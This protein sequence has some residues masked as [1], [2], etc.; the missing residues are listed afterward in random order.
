VRTQQ[1]RAARA[2]VGWPREM[3]AKHSGVTTLVIN[4]S[5]SH[6]SDPRLTGDLLEAVGATKRDVLG[7]GY[8][9]R[10]GVIVKEWCP[11][12]NS[13]SKFR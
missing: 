8:Q 13:L 11:I 10:P 6:G 12:F 7:R 4:S 9:R 3:P 1:L 2:L 5:E